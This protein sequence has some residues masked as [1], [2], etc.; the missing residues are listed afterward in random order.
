MDKTIILGLIPSVVAIG[1]AIIAVWGQLRV[2]QVEAQ[3]ALQ[4]ADADRR[5]K[6]E[7]TA[8]YRPDDNLLA[9]LKSL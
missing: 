8:R 2:K 3:L 1:A 4:K 6:T 9:F 5:A 7:Q